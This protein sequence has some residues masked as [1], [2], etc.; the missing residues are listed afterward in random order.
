MPTFF[1]AVPC[2]IWLVGVLIISLLMFLTVL[3][4]L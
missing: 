4:R 1:H 3:V 2:H